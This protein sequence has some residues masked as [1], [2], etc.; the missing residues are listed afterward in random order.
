MERPIPDFL[1]IGA[2][3]SGTT[4][5]ISD[6]KNHPD[7]YT[8]GY[9]I[10]YFTHF[11]TN[12]PDWYSSIF[13]SPGK[14]QGEKSTSYLYETACH[15]RIFDHNPGMKLIVLLREPMKRAF[16]NWAMRHTQGRLLKQV[17]MFNSRNTSPIE[18]I[19][20]SH[21]FNAYLTTDL[22]FVRH[23]EP[24]DIFERGLYVE[25][26]AHLQRFFPPEQVL[27]LISERYF[28][29]PQ[30]ELLK[31]S[32]FLNVGDFPPGTLSWKRKSEYP[33]KPDKATAET[34]R[35]FYKPY[36]ERLFGFLGYEID[37]WK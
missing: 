25:Q 30:K 7:I 20:F 33:A 3:K 17:H 26:L 15:E 9:E 18:N 4:S 21:L 36:N 32:Q 12:G 34:I 23:Q 19:G 2:A 28:H 27:I 22:D 1:L 11:Y 8:P 10:N 16:S 6:L 24:L 5:L 31:V 35:Q 37:E 14:I 29:N 13:D